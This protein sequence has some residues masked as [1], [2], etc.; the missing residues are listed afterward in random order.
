M[1]DA[2]CIKARHFYKLPVK[3]T[4][5]LHILVKKSEK[6]TIPEFGLDISKSKMLWCIKQKKREKTEKRNDFMA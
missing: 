1:L 5:S 6:I 3:D 2:N 4:I